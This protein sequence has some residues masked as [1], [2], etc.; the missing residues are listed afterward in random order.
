MQK[1]SGQHPAIL[2]LWL[3]ILILI[4]EQQAVA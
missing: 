4:G 2:I 3:P 1:G